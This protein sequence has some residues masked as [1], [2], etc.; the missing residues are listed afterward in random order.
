MPRP[1][2]VVEELVRARAEAHPDTV[3]LKWL[4]EE[5]SWLTALSLSKRAANGLLE[6]GVRPGERVALLLPNRPEFI[7]THLAIQIIGAHSVPVN[8]SQRGATLAHILTDSGASVI[9]FHDKLRDAVLSVRHR[10]PSV[11]RLV[12]CDGPAGGGIDWNTER[13]FACAD[14]EPETGAATSET[15]AGSG[16]GM[17]YTSGTTGPP[18]GVVTADYDLRPVEALVRAAGVRPGETMYTGLPLFHGNALLVSMLGSIFADAKLALAPKFSA[19]RLL[20]D[21]ARYGAVEFNTL[22]GMI[23]ILLKQP[24]SPLDREHEVRVVLSAGCPANRWRE[25]EDR[26]GIRIVE[27]FGMVDSPGILLNDTG[28]VGSMG[29]G[30]VAGIEFRVVDDADRPL[31]PQEVGEL[32]F[33]HPRGATTSYHN[34]PGATA[35]AYR[36]GWFHSG[37]LADY[38]E[39][40]FFYYRGRKRES[41]RRL[42]ENVSAW[43]IES[44]LNTHPAVLDSAAHAVASELGDEDIKV[45]VVL[46]S[47]YD[48]EPGELLLFCVER[49]AYHAVPRY[50]EFLEALPKTATERNQYATLRERGLTP[51]TW[52][53]ETE[54]S[55]WLKSRSPAR[56]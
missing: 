1:R 15:G 3:W 53:R 2:R 52:D 25:F 41:M 47:A 48:A 32:V 45:C 12:V 49:M 50:V 10:L 56:P 38:D 18:K 19:S 26:F 55:S 31:G 14:T 42:G 22:G 40:G 39:D 34:L 30:G 17:M 11:R 7:W 46:R 54:G 20:S 24:P 8:I 43:E 23:S 51:S 44:V 28:R 16:V 37:D 36:G 27:W 35:R 5:I 33:R 6:L 21:C 9:V 13:L 4:D 29:R